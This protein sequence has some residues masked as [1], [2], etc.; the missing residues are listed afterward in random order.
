MKIYPMQQNLSFESRKQRFINSESHKQLGQILNKMDDETVYNCNDYSFK[1]TRTK[2]LSL[3]NHTGNVELID[4]RTKIGKIPTENQMQGETLL[5][6]GK[7]EL[8]ID[9]KTGEIIDYHKPFFTC[10]KSGSSST[11]Q[12]RYFYSFNNFIWS[13]FLLRLF[14]VPYNHQ[15]QY[16]RQYLLD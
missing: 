9:N 11:T 3:V 5:T 14:L 4:S 1:S 6:I 2:R 10:W 8:V 12:A 15:M 16:I 13:A 7:T